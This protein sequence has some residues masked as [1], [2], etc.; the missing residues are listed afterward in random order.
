MSKAT[1]AAALRWSF[2][3]R[4]MP[5]HVRPRSA[6][7]MESGMTSEMGSCMLSSS[8]A[9]Y[10]VGAAEVVSE[11]LFRLTTPTS[12]IEER[13][14]RAPPFSSTRGCETLS[15][16][17]HVV[18]TIHDSQGPCHSVYIFVA[19]QHLRTQCSQPDD[20]QKCR[21]VRRMHAMLLHTPPAASMIS[22]PS[23]IAKVLPLDAGQ[24]EQRGLPPI[25]GHRG[26]TSAKISICGL[27]LPQSTC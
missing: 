1:P 17:C 2:R 22:L 27:H 6:K 12:A 20:T 3:R 19:A 9:G 11:P 7:W 14:P 13:E 21:D 25:S 23:I 5:F 4:R 26:Q 18:D 15:I 16:F 24:M 8:N 10:A